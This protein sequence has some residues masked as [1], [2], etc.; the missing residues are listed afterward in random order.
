[1]LRRAAPRR[2]GPRVHASNIP[3]FALRTLRLPCETVGAKDIVSEEETEGAATVVVVL[4]EERG[5]PGVKQRGG[6]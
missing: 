5:S 3:L 6:Y 1:M 4:D 2:V